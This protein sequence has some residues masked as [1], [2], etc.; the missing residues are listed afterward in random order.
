M[1]STTTT[2]IEGFQV[3]RSEPMCRN[4]DGPLERSGLSIPETRFNY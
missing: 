2:E 3:V 4:D 1:P